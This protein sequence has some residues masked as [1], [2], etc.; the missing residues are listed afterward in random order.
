MNKEQTP[1]DKWCK[2]N[3]YKI[4][5]DPKHK[6][7]L[8]FYLWSCP[9]SDTAYGAKTFEELGWEKPQQYKILKTYFRSN[10]IPFVSTTEKDIESELCK[11]NQSEKHSFCETI[12]FV[13]RTSGQ[14][15]EVFRSIRNALAHGS[16][17]IEE[18]EGDDFFYF[19][20]SRYNETK[21]KSQTE[22]TNV[23]IKKI[24][25]RIVLKSN[26]LV[27]LINKVKNGPKGR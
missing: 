9:S 10:N 4:Y 12:V 8:N 14:I 3:P 17:C 26:T 6:K 18:K 21:K 7:I 13:K 22:K 16:F 15:D 25:A 11:H 20:E 19:F 5:D 1:F 2:F 24:N 23:R 27:A